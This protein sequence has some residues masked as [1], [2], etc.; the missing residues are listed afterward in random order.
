MNWTTIIIS[1]S[2]VSSSSSPFFFS[3]ARFRFRFLCTQ[4]EIYFILPYLLRII[5]T[6]SERHN[7]RHDQNYVRVFVM[8]FQTKLSIHCFILLLSYLLHLYIISSQRQ[9]MF[10]HSFFGWKKFWEI[11]KEKSRKSSWKACNSP[12]VNKFRIQSDC[13]A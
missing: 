5:S 2:L 8:G 7:T 13:G 6:T 9:K 11:W 10:I 4:S 1:I 3:I 12:F